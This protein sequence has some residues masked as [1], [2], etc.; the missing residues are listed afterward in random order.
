MLPFFACI[1]R[2]PFSIFRMRPSVGVPLAEKMVSA[3]TTAGDRSRPQIAASRN[4]REKGRLM[5]SSKSPGLGRLFE[6]RRGDSNPY[7]FRYWLLRPARLPIP[8]LLRRG[9]CFNGECRE[10]LVHYMRRGG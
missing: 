3:R 10:A 6:C 7:T 8:P 4:K 2:T 9:H 5:V 1:S